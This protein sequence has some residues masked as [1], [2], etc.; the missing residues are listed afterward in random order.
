MPAPS[1]CRRTRPGPS[2]RRPPAARIPAFVSFDPSRSAQPAFTALV[3]LHL[4]VGLARTH[5]GEAPAGTG[6]ARAPEDELLLPPAGEIPRPPGAA[7]GR[8]GEFPV[9]PRDAPAPFGAVV[10][11]G[12]ARHEVL[13]GG[14]VLEHAAP[15]EDLHDA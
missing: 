5:L 10:L 13:L 7:L 1:P 14:E 12:G 2:R 4:A 3:V 11:E 9:A 8:P 6:Q 15:L